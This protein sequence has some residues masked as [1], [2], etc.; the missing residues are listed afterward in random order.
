MTDFHSHAQGEWYNNIR[1][2]STP[3]A[4]SYASDDIIVYDMGIQYSHECH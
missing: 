3:I 1:T 4:V 2:Y